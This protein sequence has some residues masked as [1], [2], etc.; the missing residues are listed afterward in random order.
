MERFKNGSPVLVAGS[1][2]TPDED[3]IIPYFNE[4]PE[5]KLVLA[6]HVIDEWH[7]REIES[8]LKRPAMRVSQLS[9]D[10]IANVECLIVDC[11]GLLSSIYRYGEV[12]Y[13]GGGFGVGIHNVPE[14]AVYG[15]PVLFGPNNKKFQEAQD[16]L[17]LGACYEISDSASFA[18]LMDRF[19]TEPDFLARCGKLSGDYLKD[20]AGA[21]DVIWEKLE[22]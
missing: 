5:L 16:L 14:A 21:S 2:W 11:F 3:I 19:H 17:R 15:I 4:H 6:P 18:S 13:V 22:L 12:A 7:L 1:S 20:N 9:K 8:K 10:N